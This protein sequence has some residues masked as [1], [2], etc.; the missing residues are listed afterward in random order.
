LAGPWPGAFGRFDCTFGRL[1]CGREVLAFF[2]GPS[3]TTCGCSA[4]SFAPARDLGV[5][6]SVGGGWVWFFDCECK[7]PA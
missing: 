6:L 2:D 3:A 5:L 1:T 7:F 4:A